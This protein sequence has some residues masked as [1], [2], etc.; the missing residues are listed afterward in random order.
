MLGEHV[1]KNLSW[2]VL[3]NLLLLSSAK[4]DL[5]PYMT[6]DRVFLAHLVWRKRIGGVSGQGAHQAAQGDFLMFV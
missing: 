1:G 3:F 6:S 2:Y 5:P 4:P